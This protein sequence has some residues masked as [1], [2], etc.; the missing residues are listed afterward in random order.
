MVKTLALCAAWIAVAVSLWLHWGGWPLDEY[1]LIRGSE[2]APGVITEAWEEQDQGDRGTMYRYGYAYRFTLP[3]GT[4]RTAEP[5]SHEGR[6]ATHVGASVEVEYLPGDPDVSRIRGNGS[7]SLL[8]WFLRKVVV[9]S[10]LLALMVA[11]AVAVG[12]KALK[13]RSA[14]DLSSW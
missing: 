4:H 12:R 1:R 7:A 2:I 5:P 13:D 8:E 3:D 9:G 10:L 11:P 14:V 6:I